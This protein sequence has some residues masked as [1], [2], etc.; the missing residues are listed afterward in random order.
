MLPQALRRRRAPFVALALVLVLA[1]A[2]ASAAFSHARVVT[3]PRCGVLSLMGELRS[4]TAGAGQRFVT[5]VLTNVTRHTCTLLGY[6][7]LRLLDARNR[8]LPTH[9]VRDRSRTP[10]VVR[11]TPGDSA[12]SDLRWSAIPGPGEPQRGRCEPRPARVAVRPPGVAQRLVLPWR[13][14]SVCEHGTIDV[15]PLR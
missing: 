8:P 5:L 7:G 10:R 11:L 9:V 13:L 15:R 2:A 3:T 1:L 4:P 12:R 14:G 6:P